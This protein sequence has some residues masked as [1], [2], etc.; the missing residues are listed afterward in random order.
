MGAGIW[1][2]K[3]QIT[4][5]YLAQSSSVVNVTG[6]TLNPTSASLLVNATQQL[7]ATIAPANATNQN[8]TWTSSNNAVAT[9]SSSGLVTA[10]AAGSAVITVTT[11]GWSKN[12]D[13]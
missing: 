9:V 12:R 11:Q 2:R 10:I 8:E 13:L 5:S 7:T 3:C 6:V 1:H 4:G